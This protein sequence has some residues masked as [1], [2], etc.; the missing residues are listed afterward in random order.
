MDYHQWG[1]VLTA[2]F[3]MKTGADLPGREPDLLFVARANES[4]IRANHLAGPAD[5]VIEIAS[6]ESRT[7]D[8]I[9]KYRE[10]ERGGVPEYWIVDPELNEVN[11]Y[12][13]ESAGYQKIQSDSDRL[14]SG[15][16]PGFFI[17][18]T[19]LWSS[20][21]PSTWQVLKELGLPVGGD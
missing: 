16:I 5:L 3:Q 12:C 7:R 10:Y 13:L 14:P 8:T 21:I 6:R 15:I 2:P 17:R 1:T 19:W 11:G 20:P 4:R 9:D 18:P